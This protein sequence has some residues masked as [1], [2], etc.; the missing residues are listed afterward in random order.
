MNTVYLPYT[1]QAWKDGVC[2]FETECELRI[3]YSL[4]DGRSGPIDWDVTEFHFDDTLDNKR[5]YT[6]VT[7]TEPLFQV[8]YDNLGNDFIDERLRETLA[9]HGEVDLYA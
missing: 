6:K 5:I 3:E 8:L 4:P 2:L 1:A 9:D 7:R